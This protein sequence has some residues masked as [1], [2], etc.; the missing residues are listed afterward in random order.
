[1]LNYNHLYYFHVVACEG[2]FA[3]AA[4]KLGVTQPTISEQVKTLERTLGTALFERQPAGLRLTDEGRA[5]LEHTSVMFRAGDRLREALTPPAIANVLRVGISTALARSSTAGFLRPLLAI[6]DCVPSIRTQDATELLRDLR[7]G[8]LDLAILECPPS[9]ATRSTVESVELGSVDLDAVVSSATTATNDWSNLGL[10]HYR[11]GSPFRAAVD[12]HLEARGL[13]PKIISETDDALVLLAAAARKDHLA[14][15]PHAIA[16][17]AI[18]G[19]SLVPLASV[20][21]ACA[22]FALYSTAHADLARKAIAALTSA[23]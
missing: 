3:N 4:E 9:S 12:A 20:V 14:F 18:D 8:E 22:R 19:G 11:A 15:V 7:A 23:G 13:R 21:R 6:A 10:V 5:T 17:P 16:R 1:M 2:S